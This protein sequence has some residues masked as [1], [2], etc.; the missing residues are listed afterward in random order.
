MDRDIA[1]RELHHGAHSPRVDWAIGSGASVHAEC[2]QYS[3]DVVALM[4]LEGSMLATL[5]LQLNS[6]DDVRV[7]LASQF[8]LVLKQA[9]D[10]LARPLE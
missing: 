6:S 9:M 3:F 7:N 4:D 8:K 10:P 5:A 2:L 1:S